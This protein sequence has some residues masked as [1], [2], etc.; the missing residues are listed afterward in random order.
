MF[1]QK[2][3]SEC[4]HCN[5]THSHLRICELAL[6][7]PSFYLPVKR[8]GFLNLEAFPNHILCLSPCQE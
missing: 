2:R 7:F 4:M 8:D 1:I 6:Y 5:N 3:F